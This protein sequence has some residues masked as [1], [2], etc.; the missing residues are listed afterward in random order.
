MK[1]NLVTQKTNRIAVCLCVVIMSLALQGILAP[2][3]G[4]WTKHF[5][6]K[7]LPWPEG[8]Y[9]ADMNGDDTLDVVAS[10]HDSN[11]VVWYENTL[12]K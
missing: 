12:K 11:E 3:Y 1:R 4:Q 9:V 8:L 5:I 10:G 6:D 2:A 7:N